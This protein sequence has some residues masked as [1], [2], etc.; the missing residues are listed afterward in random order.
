MQIPDE[1]VEDAWGNYLHL[2]NPP[3]ALEGEREAFFDAFISG[4]EWARKEA[5]K[6]AAEAI[7]AEENTDDP[8]FY[9]S[10]DYWQGLSGARSLVKELGDR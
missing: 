8:G 9:P 5:L 2:Q 7:E 6:E 1:A 4:A 3:V 10:P